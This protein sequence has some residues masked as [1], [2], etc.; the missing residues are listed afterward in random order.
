MR[1]ADAPDIA[2][3]PA[4]SDTAGTTPAPRVVAV[5]SPPPADAKSEPLLPASTPVDRAVE[6]RR[7]EDIVRGVLLD[8]TRA[9]ERLDVTAAKAIWPSVDDRALRRAFQQ[10]DGQQLRFASCGVSVSGRD[11]NAR[12]RGEATY[13]PK[14]GSRVLRLTERE[15][16]FNLARDN[17]RWQIVNATLQ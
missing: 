2:T 12:C 17:D 6:L 7:Q 1:A 8:Y 4:I 14:V 5:A 10:L 16:T 15:W 13:R 9:F 3:G 11:A